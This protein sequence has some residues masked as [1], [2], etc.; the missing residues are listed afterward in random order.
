MSCGARMLM[1]SRALGQR[2]VALG[3]RARHAARHGGHGA[4]RPL[5]QFG[6]RQEL[7]RSLGLGAL[8]VYGLVFINPTSPFSIFG[9][10]LQPEPRHG[11]AGV[12]LRPHRHD[13]HRGELRHDG[14]RVSGRGLG[15]FLCRARHRTRW[16][17]FS[18]AGRLLLDYIL[19]P[20]LIYVLCAIAIE[21]LVPGIPACCRHRRRGVLQHGH[22]P[23]RHRGQRA[24]ERHHA[25]V[26]AGLPGTVLRARHHTRWRTVSPGAHLSTAPLLQPEPSAPR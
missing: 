26:A 3:T 13:L 21:A 4:E 22:Q 5:E 8:I 18:P 19:M 1:N 25:G 23:A 11:A 14:A 15:V 24:P 6:Y 2:S 20:T 17:A 16:R 9:I 10:V 12:R 7:K